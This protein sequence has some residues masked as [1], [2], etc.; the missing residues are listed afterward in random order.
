MQYNTLQY[1]KIA[2]DT[3]QSRTEHYWPFWTN[4]ARK[5]GNPPPLNGPKSK[6]CF[7]P[8]K[9]LFLGQKVNGKGGTPCPPLTDGRFPKTERKKVNGKGGYRPPLYGHFP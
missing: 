1:C 8:K 9:I 4:G 7:S 3:F 2:Y 5:Q 6:K